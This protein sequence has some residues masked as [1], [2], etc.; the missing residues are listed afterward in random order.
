MAIEEEGH[1]EKN[2]V[3][4]KR[5]KQFDSKKCF[6]LYSDHLPEHFFAFGVF[7]SIKVDER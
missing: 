3:K 6:D 4:D 1:Q 5:V 7:R 2:F